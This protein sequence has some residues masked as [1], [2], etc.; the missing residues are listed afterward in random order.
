MYIFELIFEHLDGSDCVEKP[1]YKLPKAEYADSDSQRELANIEMNYLSGMK[2][3]NFVVEEDNS[4]KVYLSDTLEEKEVCRCLQI[5]SSG[6]KI[7][8]IEPKEGEIED[9][10]ILCRA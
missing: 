9:D 3:E 5:D 7:F 4:L 1:I 8:D 10:K 2:F 6:L